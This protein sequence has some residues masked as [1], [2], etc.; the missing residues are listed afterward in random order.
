MKPLK[1]GTL[2]CP[3]C[4]QPLHFKQIHGMRLIE[5]GLLEAKCPTTGKI[6]DVKTK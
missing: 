2:N 6:Y 1:K 5:K 3:C 4:K